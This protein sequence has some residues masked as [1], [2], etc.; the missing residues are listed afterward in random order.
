MYQI[1]KSATFRY[2]C[3]DRCW[4]LDIINS[5]DDNDVGMP[6]YSP[7]DIIRRFLW[8]QTEKAGTKPTFSLNP[9]KI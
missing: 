3:A 8:Y 2:V 4:K 9:S 6:V 5:N 7:G 1:S